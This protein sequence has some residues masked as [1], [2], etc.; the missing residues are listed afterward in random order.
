[1]TLPYSLEIINFALGLHKGHAFVYLIDFVK[2]G[3]VF[4]AERVMLNQVSIG[5]NGEFGMKQVSPLR[6]YALQKFNFGI[7]K[8]HS[9]R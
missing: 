8:T 3:A 5:K 2:P 7:K 9:W 4:V 6:S 1:V